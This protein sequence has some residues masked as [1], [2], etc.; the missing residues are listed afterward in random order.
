MGL[1]LY[2]SRFLL[3]V[4]GVE[5]YGVYSVVGSI[6]VL[7]SFISTSFLVASERFIAVTIAQKDS[8]LLKQ[9]FTT[10][11]ICH[12]LVAILL[13][14]LCETAG[15]WFL[16]N[17]LSIP[18]GRMSAANIVFQA[19]V[20]SCVV[21][22]VGS[23]F[24]ACIV[25]Y[26]R[27][28]FYAIVGIVVAIWKLLIIVI[29]YYCGGDK[30]IL[31]GLL[32]ALISLLSFA[33]NFVYC[34]LK[35]KEI[36]IIRYWDNNRFKEIFSFI[37]WNILKQGSYVSFTQGSSFIF[38][39]YGG[40]V[41]NAAYGITNQVYGACMSFMHN[42]QSAFSPQI[43]KKTAAS[44]YN[45]LFLLIRRSAKFSNYMLMLIAVPIILSIDFVLSTWLGTV[46]YETSKYTIVILISCFLESFNEPLNTAVLATGK[47]KPYQIGVS[48][49]WVISLILLFI[50][51]VLNTHFYLALGFRVFAELLILLLSCY[52][53]YKYLGFPYGI[54]LRKEF[55]PNVVIVSLGVIIPY[56]ALINSSLAP[57]VLFIIKSLISWVV[58]LTLVFIIGLSKSEKVFLRTIF[59]KRFHSH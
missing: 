16:N 58:M 39:I 29:V 59:L 18:E 20:F 42:V 37:G 8:V 49:I 14:L 23:P 21:G 48:L 4:L 24:H 1:T 45:N 9:V 26:E 32:Y 28:S 12:V 5:D 44:D 10:C 54:F 30:L 52:C 15:I 22:I 11:F 17:K 3:Q 27:M 25:A 7:F 51:V 40:I 41:V 47:V 31:Y 53:L 55:L 35:L 13:L 34:K 46:P 43:L 19:S 2:T 50:A 33:L 38:N 57:W 56:M 36:K 6:A